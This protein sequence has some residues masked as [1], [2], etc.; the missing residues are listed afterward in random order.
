LATGNSNHGDR[1][2]ENGMLT[3]ARA[4]LAALLA[5]GT[6][7]AAETTGAT[8]PEAIAD[9]RVAAGSRDIAEAWLIAPTTRYRHFVLGSEYEAG[10]LRVRLADGEVLTLMLDEEHV[11]EDRQPRLADLDG[12][13]R[14]EI[15]LVLTSLGEGASLAVYEIAGGKIG[16]EAK[17]PFIGRPNRWLNPAGIADFDGDGALE[18]AVVAMPHLEARLEIWGFED[19]R[20]TLE[21]SIDNVSNHRPGSPHI[22]MAAVADV[23]RDGIDDLVVPDGARLH[24]R[25][26]GF[27]GGEP[28]EIRMLFTG[29]YAD[30]P[31]TVARDG[32][33]LSAT[34]PFEDGDSVTLELHPRD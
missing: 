29:G 11:F 18:I 13:G 33:V 14:D 9:L 28:K 12:D 31:I 32:D 10:G 17:T 34:I 7:G 5:C 3:P 19:G 6:A 22:A 24:L 23:D 1:T 26:L 25:L 2:D 15:V 21:S 16:L 27:A 20:L 4:L 30:G 8:D